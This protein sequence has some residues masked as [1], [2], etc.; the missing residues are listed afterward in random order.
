MYSKTQIPKGWRLVRLGDVAEVIMGQSPPGE[1]V[2]ELDGQTPHG[3]GLPFIQGNAEFGAKF[4]SPVKW[5]SQPPK[6]SLPGDILISVRA[7]VGETNRVNGRVCIGRGLAA[8]RFR[9]ANQDFGWHLTNHFKMDLE[10]VAQG[11]TFAAIG[12]NEL[13]SLPILLPPLPE[14]RAI[15]AVLDSIDDAIERTEAVIA[16]TEQLRDSLLHQL[17]TRGVPGWHTE[18]K[19]VP[20]LGTIPADWEAVRLGEVYEAQLGKMLSPKAKQGTNPKPY[21]TN[22]NVRW[23][24]FD[25][26]DLPVMDFDEREI[27]KFRLRPGDLMVCE[28]GETGRAAIWEGQ[29]PDCYYQKALHRLRPKNEDVISKF[30][31]AVL[32]SYDRSGVLLDHSE[33]TSIFHLTR[34]RLLRMPIPNPTRVEQTAI[35]V[36]LE[37]VDAPI[38]LATSEREMLRSLKESTADALLTGRVQVLQGNGL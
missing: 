25:L 22:R 21:L 38:R 7:P 34:E 12:S 14:Q 5:C 9:K 16:A 20:G 37:G 33:Q 27:E 11:S 2:S 35:V 29:I 6:D 30:M 19:E 36:M 15:A 10:R 1:M 32:M 24:K 31:L 13:R 4:P 18:W 3:E 26:S 8:V 28:G 17:L 23:G